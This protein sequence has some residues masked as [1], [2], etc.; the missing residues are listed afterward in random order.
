M[1]M[2]VMEIKLWVLL[3]LVGFFSPLIVWAVRW[4][5]NRVVTRLDKL[6]E[7]NAQL[8][9]E[10]TRQGG[11]VMNLKEKVEEHSGILEE[12]HEKLDGHDRRIR[13][14]ELKQ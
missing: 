3:G 14:L 8:N 10:L 6:I 12:H 13:D 2:V 7:Q 9:I 11:Q 4:S 1:I 5:V